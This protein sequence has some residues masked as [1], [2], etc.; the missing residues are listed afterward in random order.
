MSPAPNTMLRVVEQAAFTDTG[1]QRRAN[2]DA[3]LARAPLY[4]VADGMGGAKAGEIASR[5]AIDILG[6]G[7]ED[8]IVKARLVELVRRA[9]RAVHEAQLADADL[10]GM[11]TTT[12]VAHVGD[13][14]LTV[15]HVGDSRAYLLRDGSLRRLTDDHS[16][17]EEMRRSGRLT[18]EEAANHPQRS[19]ITRALGPDPVVEVDVR[20]FA[21]QAG[22]VVLL[23]S[24]G[25]TSMIPESRITEL[26]K[27]SS[28]LDTAGRALIAAANAAGGRDNI[29]VVL[30]RIGGI[31][32]EDPTV[33]G[34]P[35]DADEQATQVGLAA[36]GA[37]V[38]DLDTAATVAGSG[39]AGTIDAHEVRAAAEAAGP[40]TQ[41][42]AARD[43]R[44]GRRKQRSRRRSRAFAAT[45]AVVIT[46]G[47]VAFAGW[48]ATRV[49]YFVGS[50]QG[51]VA[52]YQG[53]PYDLPFGVRLYKPIYRSGVPTSSLS[54]SERER[55][56]DHQLRS[57][58]DS[59]DL[60]K[61]VEREELR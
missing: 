13:E 14:A 12:T 59:Q 1:R 35:A 31:D 9:N 57:G 2:E 21:L 52:I 44:P 45:I 6:L 38:P 50:S 36:T 25:L 32:D 26:L 56:Y 8:G 55:L 51:F 3:M 54:A 29:T 18:A 42:L 48:A 11:G 34:A 4:A 23:C 27:E 10:S 49:T 24:D 46:L 39:S 30:L 60:I 37:S 7:V 19:I 53:V 20:E 33:A 61:A 43:P 22:D 41:P 58:Q 16:L 15:A 17:V 40:V 47:I 5:T 28:R